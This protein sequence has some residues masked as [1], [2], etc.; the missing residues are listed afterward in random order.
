M[1]AVLACGR[2]PPSW[3]SWRRG[4]SWF[5]EHQWVHYRDEA[6]VRV[7]E[8]FAELIP[9]LGAYEWGIAVRLQEW[10]RKFRL[11]PHHG[12]VIVPKAFR[13]WVH[14]MPTSLQ[15][16]RNVALARSI[17]YVSQKSAS[18]E[19]K[20]TYFRSHELWCSTE[21]TRSLAKP[22]FFLAESVICNLD[23]AIQG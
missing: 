11:H 14:Q 2:C 9:S 10:R 13:M 21:G 23:M 7:W 5:L 20:I 19:V 6:Q 17:W 8:A 18:W 4:D 15:R 3:C 12:M 1:V 16:V 22:H